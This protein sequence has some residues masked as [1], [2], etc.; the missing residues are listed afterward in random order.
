V[1]EVIKFDGFFFSWRE[2][3]LCGHKSSPL[4][5]TKRYKR[6]N[7]KNGVF[8]LNGYTSCSSLIKKRFFA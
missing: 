2:K 5:Q 8:E 7:A 6:K 4:R 1:L 3:M